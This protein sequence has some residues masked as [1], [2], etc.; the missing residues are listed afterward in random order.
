MMKN[1]LYKEF[2]LAIHP[3]TYIFLLL[4]SMVLIPNYPYMVIF[5]Y[6]ILGVFFIS[7]NGRETK[8]IYY[9]ML[10]PIDRSEL[11]KSRILF[12]SLIETAQIL[13]L[14]PFIIIKNI[15]IY[16]PNLAGLDA[17]IS[18]LAMGFLIYSIYNYVFF[19]NY[20]KN[21]NK[22]GYSFFIASIFSTIL[23]II[24]ESS[25]HIVPFVM[26]Y[27]DTPDS[28]FLFGKLILLFISIMIFC[29]SNIFTYRKS[30][31]EFKKVDL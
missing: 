18:L 16:S 25:T 14:V 12:V 28:I 13:L 30:V 5:F 23:M 4:S 20:Y 1:I 7:L 8:D 29:V 24:I 21:V 10:L 2:K 3:S 27:I 9:S 11:V 31:K 17:N 19:T 26:N 22:V 15:F 6:S